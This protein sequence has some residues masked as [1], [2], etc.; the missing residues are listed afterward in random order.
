MDTGRSLDR[1]HT[2]AATLPPLLAGRSAPMQALVRAVDDLAHAEVNLLLQ[3][4][5]GTG[6]RA[7]AGAIHARSPRAA[8][9]F[10][11]VP[12]GELGEAEARRELFDEEGAGR[13]A[14]SLPAAT[15]YVGSIEAL[16]PELQRRL[17]LALN[18]PGGWSRVRI[19]SGANT[20]LEE[21]VR[22]GR[23]R[24]D[25]F[26][27]LGVVRVTIP[28]LRERC[29]DV[30]VVAERVVETWCAARGRPVVRLGRAVLAELADDV[31]PGNARELEGILVRTLEAGGDDELRVERLRAIL[32]RRSRQRPTPDVFPLRQ[33]ERDY[34]AA[35]LVGCNWNQSLAARRLGIGRNTL[36]RK[37]KAFG[38]VK[39]HA[40]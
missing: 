23:F 5:E 4:E 1:A 39:A 29:E 22:M 20:P 28:P 17:L 15:L 2:P 30:P 16:G 10:L 21:M 7:L 12:L 27:R 32:G 34:I 33:L 9:P 3:G 31:W 37:I 26:F 35:V 38:L 36:L 19:V 13:R 18:S 40:A 25:L 6:K 11:E 8:G 24:R 14:T